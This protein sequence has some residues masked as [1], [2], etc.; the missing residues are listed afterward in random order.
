VVLDELHKYPQWKSWIK[1]EYD[2]HGDRIRFFITGS[3]RLDIYRKGGDA[4]QG[5]YH[6]HRLHSLSIG[7]TERSSMNLKPGREID[8]PDRFNQEVLSSM[9]HYGPFPEPFLKQD[10]RSLRRWRRERMDRFFREDVRDL[11]NVRNL[12]S[13]DLL[14]DMFEDRVGSLLSLQSLREDDDAP[15][16]WFAPR[17]GKRQKM[18]PDYHH[19]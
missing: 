17:M 13:R 6:A 1:G 3:A 16:G 12:A 19:G 11:E 2:A 15:A 10:E 4:H 9:L 8:F 18:G 5:R 14:A 7:E